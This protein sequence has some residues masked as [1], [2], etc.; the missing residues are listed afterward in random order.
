MFKNLRI[1]LVLLFACGLVYPLAVN[2]AANLL[3]P[4]KANGSLIE[5]SGKVRGSELIGQAFNEPKYFSGRVSSI[6][7][8]GAGSGSNN[9]AASNEELA[10]RTKDDI[11][12][13]LVANP[14]VKK[15][16]IPADLL[17]NSGSGLDPHISPLAALIQVPRISKE[18]GIQEEVLRKL[19]KEQTEGR[20]LGIFGEPRVNVLML[21]RSLD[22][23]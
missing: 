23:K 15:E 18:R 1:V 14:G 5:E 2:G 4:E 20:Q 22:E 19:I 7:Y 12:A 11:N 9:Y 21:N 10:K 6:K 3:M 8:D 13:F 17:T 16:D